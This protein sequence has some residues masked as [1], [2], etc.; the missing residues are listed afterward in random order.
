MFSSLPLFNLCCL[1]LPFLTLLSL[2]PSFCSTSPL[3]LLTLPFFLVHPPSFLSSS[4]P[5]PCSP[6]P[7]SPLLLLLLLLQLNPDV[8]A[9]QRK[10]I[11]E[12]RRCEEMERKLRFL[13]SQLEK[14]GIEIRPA[15]N[16]EAPDPQNMIDLEV[17]SVKEK[18]FIRYLHIHIYY[19]LL[20]CY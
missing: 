8:S 5:H 18:G 15:G 10:F 3:L 20:L 12:V 4:S 17:R 14:A 7:S 11:N 19:Q 9:F 2:P 13:R 6:L 1:H 16:V